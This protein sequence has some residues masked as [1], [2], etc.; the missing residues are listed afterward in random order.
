MTAGGRFDSSAAPSA[1][2]RGCRQ[3][4]AVSAG[5][6][7]R[8]H[9]QLLGHAGHHV[10]RH[11]I[12]YTDCLGIHPKRHGV[13][14]QRGDSPGGWVRFL[15]PMLPFHLTPLVCPRVGNPLTQSTGMGF[16]R[17]ITRVPASSHTATAPPLPEAQPS[18]QPA[19]PEH[20]R[21]LKS[22]HATSAPVPGWERGQP[23][24]GKGRALSS[25]T[26]AAPAHGA[27]PLTGRVG[28]K[29]AVG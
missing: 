2:N 6:R 22:P 19:A 28:P 12:F 20:P 14:E 7:A 9:P 8:P 26:R 24:T 15:F 1:L 16:W 17:R 21:T 4:V 29:R 5:P 11:S 18:S 3:T 27:A 23:P 13:L 25:I 10:T